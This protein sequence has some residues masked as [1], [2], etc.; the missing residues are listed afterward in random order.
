MWGCGRQRLGN[1]LGKH[2]G[3]CSWSSVWLLSLMVQ[4]TG[5]IGP[6]SLPEQ[7][8][9]AQW[10]PTRAAGRRGPTLPV[11][12]AS[13]WRN[14]GRKGT[15]KTSTHLCPLEK[16]CP[17]GGRRREKGEQGRGCVQHCA[18][19]PPLPAN[20]PSE[21]ELS[22]GPFWP[23]CPS[24]NKPSTSV[25]HSGPLHLLFPLP[26]IPFP[27][28]P[29]PLAPASFVSIQV[30]MSSETPFLTTVFEYDLPA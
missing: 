9:L 7:A 11:P 12:T 13:V 18:S 21:L 1:F 16:S 23:S 8:G 24:S 25:P 26:G 15:L 30:V 4:R 28:M 3:H 14:R 6:L 27:Q 10:C 17:A 19:A 5:S 29:T 20:S 2:A 22:G